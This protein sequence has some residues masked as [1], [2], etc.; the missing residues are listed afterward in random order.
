MAIEGTRGWRIA[1]EK[2]RHKVDVVVALA[3]ACLACVRR[4]DV[5]YDVG[6]W[7]AGFAKVNDEMQQVSPWR[8]H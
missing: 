4:Q 1:K 7:A 8:I 6:D 5:E 2:A 3:M